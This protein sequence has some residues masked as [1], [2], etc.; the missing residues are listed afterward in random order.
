MYDRQG[1]TE[2]ATAGPGRFESDRQQAGE[3]AGVRVPMSSTS[4]RSRA[5]TAMDGRSRRLTAI[6]ALARPSCM[7]LVAATARLGWSGTAELKC[8]RTIKAGPIY[9]YLSIHPLSDI[10]NMFSGKGNFH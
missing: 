9:F 10:R 1:G 8:A 2:G 4:A 6:A 5:A 7:Q 3:P